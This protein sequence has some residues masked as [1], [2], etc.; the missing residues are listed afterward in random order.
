MHDEEVVFTITS[1]PNAGQ[2]A[3]RVTSSHGIA[4]WV[5]TSNVV[6][7]DTIPATANLAAGFS[8]YSDTVQKV[9]EPGSGPP[10]VPDLDGWGRTA[11]V[12]L[13]GALA[14]IILRRNKRFA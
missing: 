4:S 13:L 9:W 11:A 1:G 8:V 2:S 7:T 3:I 6:G 12:T 5:Y 14:V 10:P